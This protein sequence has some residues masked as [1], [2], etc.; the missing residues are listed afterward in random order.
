[1]Q[2]ARRRRAWRPSSRWR[3]SAVTSR[4]WTALVRIMVASRSE[5]AQ[6]EA[7]RA[8]RAIDAAGREALDPWFVTWLVDA[9]PRRLAAR[10]AGAC[11][12]A[13]GRRRGRARTHA[14][15]PPPGR[16]SPRAAAPGPASRTP[17]IRIW[18]SRRSSS[19]S[20]N[21]CGVTCC[22]PSRVAFI[23]VRRLSP[24]DAACQSAI[25]PRWSRSSTRA[26]GLSRG[27]TARSS[28]GNRSPVEW[29]STGRRNSGSRAV[30]DSVDSI[31]GIDYQCEGA[32][33]REGGPGLVQAHPR[34]WMCGVVATASCRWR[35]GPRRPSPRGRPCRPRPTC[36][37]SAGRR[38]S[39]C[40]PRPRP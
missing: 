37:T 39:C 6:E 34:R 2:P 7:S 32:G 35:A 10:P 1:M 15:Q 31:D 19:R 38:P 33:A 22:H 11:P 40:R 26:A 28:A 8:A 5:R 17:A 23:S 13:R 4:C 25:T 12:A 16:C 21:T 9:Q 14:S 29:S 36:R 24:T 27:A 30:V 3:L 18:S 20:A